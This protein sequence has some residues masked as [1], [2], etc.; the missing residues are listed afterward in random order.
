MGQIVTKQLEVFYLHVQ[1]QI[2]YT[3]AYRAVRPPSTSTTTAYFKQYGHNLYKRTSTI[4]RDLPTTSTKEHQDSEIFSEHP[5][6][7]K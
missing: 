1:L 5:E 3:T 6:Y 7:N 4:N 2:T